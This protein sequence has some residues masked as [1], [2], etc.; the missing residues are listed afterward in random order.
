MASKDP[1]VITGSDNGKVN[2]Y[3]TDGLKHVEVHISD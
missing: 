2:V 3:R 1:I